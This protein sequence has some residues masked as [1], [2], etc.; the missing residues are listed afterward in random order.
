MCPD[1]S[2]IPR[3]GG[4]AGGGRSVVAPHAQDVS[5]VGSARTP[6]GLL[7]DPSD[8]LGTVAADDVEV[9]HGAGGERCPDL[10]GPGGDTAGSPVG[11]SFRHLVGSEEQGPSGIAERRSGVVPA[12]GI[13]VGRTD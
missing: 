11:V 12:R 9:V 6:N 4:S 5:D 3:S 1:T 2:P 7:V 8:R 13:E 10:R